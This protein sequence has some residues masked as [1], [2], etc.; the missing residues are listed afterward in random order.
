[1]H[2]SDS[3]EKRYLVAADTGG[4]FTDVAVYDTHSRRVSY[5]KTLTQYGDLVDGVLEGL[6]ETQVS[7]P[8]TLLFKHGT[9]HVSSLGASATALC[10]PEPPSGQGSCHRPGQRALPRG[11]ARA[12]GQPALANANRT[13]SIEKAKTYTKVN[14]SRRKSSSPCLPRRM[15]IS[16]MAPATR[17]GVTNR[18]TPRPT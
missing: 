10:C 18:L 11:S 14:F 17:S 15:L 4:T 13:A 1:M 2:V 3:P 12:R 6:E 16:V 9:T 5:G 8:Q 7:L